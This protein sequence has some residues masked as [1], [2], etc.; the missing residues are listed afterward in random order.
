MGGRAG[1]SLA[2]P[3]EPE[4]GTVAPDNTDRGIDLFAS[5]LIIMAAIGVA[6]IGIRIAG[7]LLLG[8]W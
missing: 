7:R 1:G 5:G 3:P 4:D 2:F 8:I 6:A